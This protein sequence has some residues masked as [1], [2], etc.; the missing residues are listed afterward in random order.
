MANKDELSKLYQ[1]FHQALSRMESHQVAAEQAK[2]EVIA[3]NQEIL[4][5][6]STIDDKLDSAE[7]E[8]SKVKA[9]GRKKS[10]V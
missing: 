8:K 10:K 6:Q 4:R 1:D 7:V 9:K 5:F 3:I 2:R